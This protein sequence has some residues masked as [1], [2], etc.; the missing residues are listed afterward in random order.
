MHKLTAPTLL[1]LALSIALAGCEK[2]PAPLAPPTAEAIAAFAMA[3]FSNDTQQISAA[4]KNGMPVDQ[5]DESGN[6]A[7]MLS[8]FDGHIETMQAL[9]TAGA[10]INL[11]DSNGRT[12]LMF[13]SSGPYPAAVRL[14]LEKGA[15]IN[16]V[17]N[18]DR[19]SA[20]MFAAAEGLSPVVDILLEHGADPK[21]KD[22]DNDTAASFAKQR[23]F[24]D[25]AQKLQTLIDKP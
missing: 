10:D 5:K 20:L 6:T 3:A 8:S 11:R 9:L 22:K 2:K 18:V 23:G 24:T 17:D 25:L 16:A 13:A 12:A 19:F 1:L 15:E 14:L 21:L 7:L 4:I